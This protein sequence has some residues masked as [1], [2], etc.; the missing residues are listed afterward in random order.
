MI[1]QA[2]YDQTDEHSVSNR[3]KLAQRQH[4]IRRVDTMAKCSSYV[5]KKEA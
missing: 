4:I 1:F 5:L 2:F 3:D